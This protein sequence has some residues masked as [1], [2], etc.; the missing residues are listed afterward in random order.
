MRD[1]ESAEALTALPRAEHQTDAQGAAGGR[2]AGSL[3]E[4][5]KPWY[6]DTGEQHRKESDS[7]SHL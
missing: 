2:A 5:G 3:P 6:Q 7:P 1:T 4:L